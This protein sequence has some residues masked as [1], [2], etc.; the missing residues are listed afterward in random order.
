MHENQDL[1]LLLRAN[2]PYL[3]PLEDNHCEAAFVKTF[4]PDQVCR[5][6]YKLAG[7]SEDRGTCSTTSGMLLAKSKLWE[8]I[9][10]KQASFTCK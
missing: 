4:Q 9:Q 7:I 3:R 6:N 1:S 5:F 8:T 10:D 2:F